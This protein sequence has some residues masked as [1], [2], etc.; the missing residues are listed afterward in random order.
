MPTQ[1]VLDLSS[2]KQ[3]TVSLD[4]VVGLYQKDLHNALIRDAM[5]QRFE[6]TY[7]LGY[8]MLKRYLELSEPNA[9]EIDHM[10]F[11]TMIRTAAERGLIAN[12]WDKWKLYRD[13]RNITS[14]TYNEKKAIQICVLI[15]DFLVEVQYL[16]VTLQE[17]VQVL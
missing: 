10:S 16:S 13:A 7:E 9:E 17:R 15:P 14:H 8:K 5:I 3:A 1:P 6:Y 12:G 4:E 11:P 2:L